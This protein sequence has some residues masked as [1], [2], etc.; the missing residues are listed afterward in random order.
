[1]GPGET[2]VSNRGRCIIRSH[3]HCPQG[4]AAHIDT[5]ENPRAAA[6]AG[7]AH[8]AAAAARAWREGG[9]T[10]K[11]LLDTAMGIIR[12]GHIP[13]WP[14]WRCAHA[15][16]RATAYRY[17]PSRSA[18]ITA[19]IEASLGPV[20]TLA[21]G[22]QPTAASVCANCSAHVP[23]LHGVRAA[24]A[25]RGAAVAGA[26]GAGAR[27]AAGGRALPPRPPHPHP[28]ARHRAAGA[29]AGRR[30]RPGGCTMRCRWSTASSPT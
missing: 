27:R 19:V 12:D 16:S 6:S 17:F 26:V 4:A 20:R 14:R 29:A 21:S 7:R 11:L 13:R 28:R 23:A 1:V 18:L 10:F 9:S 22:Q 30:V 25:R 24:A 3:G 5:G 2:C 8:A 15:V